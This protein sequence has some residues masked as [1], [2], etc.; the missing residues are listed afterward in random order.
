MV[1]LFNPIVKR[2]QLL[3]AIAENEGELTPELLAQLEINDANISERSEFL[4]DARNEALAQIANADA[5]VA[6][7]QL[8]KA[9]AQRGIDAIDT[10]LKTAVLRVGIINAGTYKVSLRK[11]TAV[12][13]KDATDIAEAYCSYKEPTAG[14]WEPDKNKLKKALVAGE[15][16]PGVML[17]ERE[18][19]QIK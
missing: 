18:N 13:I 6:R 14:K 4:L 16:I 5:Q 19:L 1:N 8:F 3:E 17:E 2:I 7:L 12:V 11:S 15:S 9:Q 10:Q